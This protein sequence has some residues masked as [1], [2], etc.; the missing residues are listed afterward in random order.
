MIT[1]I[2][3]VGLVWQNGYTYPFIAGDTGSWKAGEGA[4]FTIINDGGP[5]SDTLGLLV[6]RDQRHPNENQTHFP[7]PDDRDESLLWTEKIPIQNE[8]GRHPAIPGIA[9]DGTEYDVPAP[10]QG[11]RPSNI[12]NGPGMTEGVGTGELYCEA[13]SLTQDTGLSG[14]LFGVNFEIGPPGTRSSDAHAH[15]LVILTWY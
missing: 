3:G 14:K 10:K 2:S 8:L 11:A 12:Q 9:A 4:P 6:V 15:R 7:F 13:T 1:C 5:G